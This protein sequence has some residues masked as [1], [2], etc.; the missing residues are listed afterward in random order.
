M[1]HVQHMRLS[2]DNE[3]QAAKSASTVAWNHWGYACQ[4]PFRAAEDTRQRHR[5]GKGSSWTEQGRAQQE[6]GM[7]RIAV[8]VLAL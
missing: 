4:E 2:L 5:H 7:R 3:C 8:E 6:Q 1:G